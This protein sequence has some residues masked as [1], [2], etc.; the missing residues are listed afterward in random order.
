MKKYSPG[1]RQQARKKL[2]KPLQDFIAS[3]TLSTLYTGIQKKHKLSLYQ[4]FLLADI[5][6]ATLIGLEQESALE[7][8][9]HQAMH[10]LS[11]EGARELVADINDRIFKEAKRRLEE[12]ILEPNFLTEVKPEQDLSEEEQRE[13]AERERI[14]NMRDD[15][16]ELLAAVQEDEAKEKI[17]HEAQKKEL[18]DSLREIDNRPAPT[19]EEVRGDERIE[20]ELGI[21]PASKP[22]ESIAAQKLSAPTVAKPEDVVAEKPKLANETAPGAVPQ[23]TS[24]RTID[25]Y[26]E[27]IE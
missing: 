22:S 7:T 24:P 18:E 4:I 17:I 26:H 11:N 15:D 2:P 13:N 12:N 20:K 10:E 14:E 19:E 5:V 21:G 8:N 3:P 16:P 6:N 23:K 1:E 27:P 9:L 25:P